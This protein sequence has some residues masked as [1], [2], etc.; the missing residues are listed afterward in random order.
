[1]DIRKEYN[2]SNTALNQVTGEYWIA[3]NKEYVALYGRDLWLFRTNGAFVWHRPDIS[4]PFKVAFLEGNRLL[5]SGGKSAYHLISLVDGSSIWNI[6]QRKREGETSHFA[7]SHDGLFAYD[8]YYWIN[9]SFLV[10]IDLENGKKEESVLTGGFRSTRGIICD[11]ND[12]PC[13]LQCQTDMVEDSYVCQ[14]GVF[15]PSLEKKSGES[16]WKY[17]WK[18]FDRIR[19]SG[20]L[21]DAETILTDHLTV[22]NPT[23]E[24]SSPLMNE[25]DSEVLSKEYFLT[26]HQDPSQRYITL[27]YR[28][29]NVVVDCWENKIAACY[30]TKTHILGCLVGDEY[31]ICIANKIVRK[32]FPLMEDFPT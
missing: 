5:V 14:Q 3:C 11:E 31:W 7:F 8:Y 6:R 25:K 12:T 26:Y 10:K 32:A 30:A 1:M 16:V 21:R 18:T 22:W 29:A 24:S 28:T 19:P 2:V 23:K 20:F 15:C 4:Y 13:L 17:K 27:V 9:Q